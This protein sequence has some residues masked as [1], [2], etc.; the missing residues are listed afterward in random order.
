MG[1]DY[2]ELNEFRFFLLSLRQYFEYWVAF[3][4][5]DTDG[6]RR[7]SLKEFI[8][9]QDK[10]EAWV[11]KIGDIEGRNLYLTSTKLQIS[12]HNYINCT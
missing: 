4:R 7:I 9:A 10:I 1:D 11:G 3:C 5:T 6:D 2:I 12:T 8:A